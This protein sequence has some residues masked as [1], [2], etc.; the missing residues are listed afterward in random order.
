MEVMQGGKAPAIRLAGLS[1]ILQPHTVERP[2]SHIPASHRRVDRY[3][4]CS[5]LVVLLFYTPLSS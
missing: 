1:S 5:L 3:R 4:A 2:D